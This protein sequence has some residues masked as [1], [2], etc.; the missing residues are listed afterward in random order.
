MKRKTIA[1]CVTGFNRENESRIVN[2]IREG[3]LKHNINMLAFATMVKK[4]EFNSEH[5]LPEN[6]ILGE[7][8]I[9]ELINYDIT[10]GIVI[11]GESIV[12][13]R[14]ISSVHKKA[15]EHGI[16]VM[17]INDPNHTLDKNII[18]SDKITM[19]FIVRHLVEDHG[20]KKINFIGGFP[21]NLQTEERLNAYKKI[22]TEHNIPI[23]EKRIAYG[24]FW[25]KSYDCT[26]EFIR[27]GDIPEAIVC[28]S[29]TM[30]FFCMDALKNNGFRIP[31]DVIVT[32]FDGISD[33]EAYSPT[34]T[35]ARLAFQE[36]GEKAV[37]L[38]ED[39]W[40]GKKVDD[41]IYI[42]SVLIRQQSCGC[43]S[44]DSHSHLDFYS[45]RYGELNIYKEFNSHLINLNTI[46]ANSETSAEVY[47]AAQQG[48]NFFK[49][50]KLYIC[51]CPEVENGISK[52]GENNGYRG[53]SE[54]ML[55]MYCFGGN[56][57]VNTEFRAAELV[58]EKFLEGEKAAFMAFTP[59]YFKD[60]FIG[61]LA[62]QPSK[63]LG[64][65]DPFATWVL[66]LANNAGSFYMKNEL[67]F[68]VKELENLYIRDPLTG[69]YNR[70]GMEKLKYEIIEQAKSMKEYVT[71]LC[72]DIDNLK[73]I[74][75]NFGHEAGDNAILRTAAAINFSVPRD[76]VCT[77]TG[78]DEFCVILHHKNED[79]VDR[80][81]SEIDKALEKYNSTG[82]LPYKIGC[83]CGYYSIHSD[84]LVSV[85][86][87]MIAAD[88]NMY[89]VKAKKKTI[90][91]STKPAE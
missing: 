30:A 49:L 71:I 11:L 65:G 27:S 57:P 28:A 91:Q 70:R 4:P 26:E 44:T 72:A 56:V 50:D 47:S 6:V 17:N 88:E 51:V 79:D 29:D 7:S 35:T 77:R 19:E 39:I 23:E 45:E 37:E 89:K 68:V 40:A 25:K 54:K 62:Y 53:I 66:S 63:V 86:S 33:C 2:G 3:C 85:D 34:L 13:E 60:R 24:G 20:L 38:F 75:D 61:Y 5:G 1:V 16:P 84:S 81:I 80:Y 8:E 22:L 9:F 18:L 59:L 12:D 15:A 32:G 83:S 10:D 87:M 46:F 52:I 41:T 69:L 58:P 42:D 43:I 76:S 55:C 14:V 78:G 48:A 67:G 31:E 64:Y 90:R 74:N 36:S 73:P 21:G 82:G